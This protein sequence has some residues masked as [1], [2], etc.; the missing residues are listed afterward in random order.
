[1]ESNFTPYRVDFRSRFVG[2]LETWIEDRGFDDALTLFANFLQKQ[3]DEGADGDAII[4]M[5]QAW[6]EAA[7][8]CEPEPDYEAQQDE[9]DRREY[10]AGKAEGEL[11]R[12]ERKIYG[13]DLA[14]QFHAQDD[15]NRFNRGED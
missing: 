5:Q 13:D 4:S 6:E 14:E 2:E 1:M 12:A 3:I 15:L 11:R 7:R 10:E 9:R 8:V